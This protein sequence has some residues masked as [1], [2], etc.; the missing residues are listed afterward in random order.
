VAGPG[1]GIAVAASNRDRR[2][3]GRWWETRVIEIDRELFAARARGLLPGSAEFDALRCTAKR[4]LCGVE[5]YAK[6]CRV[7]AGF[8]GVL[9]ALR[10]ASSQ[11][12]GT[13][14]LRR[15]PQARIGSA[16]P[17]EGASAFD[18]DE[19]GLDR[20]REGEVVELHQ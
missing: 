15:G 18:L 20:C 12:W 6:W 2:G 8:L 5:H 17:D 1:E 14:R 13:R 10:S 7:R 9:R 4:R 3:E 16:R 19:I 11:A